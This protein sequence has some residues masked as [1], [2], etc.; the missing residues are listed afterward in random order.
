VNKKLDARAEAWQ[1]READTCNEAA[2]GIGSGEWREIYEAA[3]FF[4]LVSNPTIPSSPERAPGASACI[5]ARA[6][7]RKS[8][9]WERG[10]QA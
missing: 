6:F 9:S 5:V 7:T 1:A 8:T 2:A 10:S 3:F 4:R